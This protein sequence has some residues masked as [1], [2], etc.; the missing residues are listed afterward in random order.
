MNT[1]QLVL[2]GLLSFGPGGVAL[3]GSADYD[4]SQHNLN[5]QQAD[6]Q[7]VFSI[8]HDG[9]Y[10]TGVLANANIKAQGT[11]FIKGDKL[12]V[13][14]EWN[15]GG[16]SSDS[17]YLTSEFN[18]RITDNGHLAGKFAFFSDS[19]EPAYLT[20]IRNKHSVP[21]PELNSN[22][23]Q[24]VNDDGERRWANQTQEWVK[25]SDGKYVYLT[26]VG[27]NPRQ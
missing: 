8:L 13:E 10:G 2:A 16:T 19:G 27:C 24:K 7:C 20:I 6:L 17:K 23:L 18:I 21:V 22:Q 26:V 1:K 25:L 4:F 5:T 15:T 14:G 9:A 12:S 3:A 11:A